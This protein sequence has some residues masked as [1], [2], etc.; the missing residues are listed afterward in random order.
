MHHRTKYLEKTLSSL[1][2]LSGLD[3]VTVYI[4]QD[5]QDMAVKDVVL[6][7][8]EGPLAPPKTRS[9][10]HW[11]RERLPQLGPDQASV[12]ALFVSHA[13]CDCG[14][15]TLSW[16]CPIGNADPGIWNNLCLPGISV[17]VK[18]RCHILRPCM[19]KQCR[20]SSFW[21]HV[22]AAV[23]SHPLECKA[24]AVYSL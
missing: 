22:P 20:K 7:F 23:C 9:F 6:K 11:Q 24:H 21:A 14:D 13:P 19:H 8:E 2:E 5:G 12:Q 10:E 16:E 18:M 15:A 3:K 1:A 4:S 17:I